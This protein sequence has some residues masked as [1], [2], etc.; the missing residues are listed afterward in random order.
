MPNSNQD[1]SL[2]YESNGSYNFGGFSGIVMVIFDYVIVFPVHP[3][4]SL[5]PSD[6]YMRQ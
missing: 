2:K 3:I 6:A 5:R 1:T 4:N